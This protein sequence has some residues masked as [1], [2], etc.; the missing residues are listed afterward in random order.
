[1]G[2]FLKL[3]MVLRFHIDQHEKLFS[4]LC[5][6]AVSE[7]SSHWWCSSKTLR[8]MQI[9]SHNS[10]NLSVIITSKKLFINLIFNAIYLSLTEE[11]T[12]TCIVYF[13]IFYRKFIIQKRKT[14]DIFNRFMQNTCFRCS[15][16]YRDKFQTQLCKWMPMFSHG[17]DMFSLH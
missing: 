2:C 10:Q 8:I 6:I 9:Y 3:L 13:F 17:L 16:K 5:F 14:D 12:C 1:M 7:K 11:V 15:P 4:S